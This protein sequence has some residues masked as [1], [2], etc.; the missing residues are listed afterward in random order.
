MCKQARDIILVGSNKNCC[1]AI[2]SVILRT[3]LMVCSTK[4]SRKFSNK[5][6]KLAKNTHN[7]TDITET[8][9]LRES[10]E[11]RESRITCRLMLL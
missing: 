2:S 7:E 10:R 5:L 6:L 8:K 11:S 1:A 4:S 9:E 3:F